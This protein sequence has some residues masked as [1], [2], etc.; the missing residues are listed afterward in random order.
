MSAISARTLALAA[1]AMLSGCGSAPA[2]DN[3]AAGLAIAASA[4]DPKTDPYYTDATMTADEVLRRNDL[5]IAENN[6]SSKALTRLETQDTGKFK[7]LQD[8]C[9]TAA[10][11]LSSTNFRQVGRCVE[12]SW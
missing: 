11:G 3:S 10:H 2:S 5:A 1:T 6:R 7:R 12:V 8:R 4:I 9:S